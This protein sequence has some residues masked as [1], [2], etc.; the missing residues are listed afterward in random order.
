MLLDPSAD[1]WSAGL[2]A[3][4]VWTLPQFAVPTFQNAL[5][6]EEF[7][8]EQLLSDVDAFAAM[9]GRVPES[10]R[11]ILVPSWVSPDPRRGLGPLDL[12]SDAGVTNALMRMNLRLVERC[13]GERRVTLL[14]SQRWLQAA[15]PSAYHA[16]LWYMSK[17]PFTIASSRRRP[18]TSPRLSPASTAG[19]GKW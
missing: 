8:V 13:R 3:V 15:G 2:D 1:F 6:S 16:R 19:A 7:S 4:V 18:T 10:V 14:D 17:T 5:R 11:N 9:L 12:M